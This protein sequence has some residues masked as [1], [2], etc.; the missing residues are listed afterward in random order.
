MRM[1]MAAL[2]QLRDG[3]FAKVAM[4][5]V[6]RLAYRTFVHMHELSLRFHLER[7]TGG[8]T[9]VLE[10]G[11]NGIEVIVRTIILQLVPTI[12]ELTMVLAVL[13][14]QFDW[15]YAVTIVVTIVAYMA[16]TYRATE[17]RIGIRRKMNES[18]T[19]A[20]VKAIDSL[21]NYETVKYFS[22]EE[23][24]ASRYDRAMARYEDASV[25]A[26]TSLA[27]LNAGQA[28]IF[29]CGLAATMVM[30][31]IGIRNGTNT[32]GDF[33]LVN[34]MMIQLYLPLNLMGMVYREIK[35]AITDIERSYP[36]RRRA[37]RL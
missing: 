9:R 28:F 37:L 19:D 2:T 22:A 8:L 1:L 30:C 12:V 34:A 18:D 27:V 21:L 5:A 14:F 4:H 25:K 11:R 29:T 32:V 6:R 23:R 20:N 26:Y 24:E 3:L 31:A 33:V 15:R 35:Q 13:L 7:K 16:Y 17:W 36:L 10:R